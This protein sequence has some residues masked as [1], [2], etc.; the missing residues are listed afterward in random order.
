MKYLLVAILAALGGPASPSQSV[1]SGIPPKELQAE[2]SSVRLPVDNQQVT[3]SVTYDMVGKKIALEWRSQAHDGE[4]A[5]V[6]DEAVSFWPTAVAV[7]GE[8]KLLVAGKRDARGRDNTVIELWTLAPIAQGPLK[9]GPLGGPL[10]W[11]P[12]SVSITSKETVYDRHDV[13]RDI[14]KAMFVHAG[15]VDSVL[16][17]FHDSRD[18][19]TISTS[20]GA[21]SVELSA[22][23][24]PALA[25]DYTTFWSG[26]HSFHGYTYVLGR[27][28]ETNA[29]QPNLVL[30]DA[31]KDGS[32]DV[33]GRYSL[34][35]NGWI[36]MGFADD[37][38]WVD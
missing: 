28:W 11:Q 17:L 22:Q 31:D 9:V 29:G 2:W 16:A 4:V 35:V 5:A 8:N 21:Y 23:T 6:Q 1:S 7:F 38:N 10:T 34:D 19:Y 3:C 20:T 32:L 14:V 26:E 27:S 12:Y 36:T 25:D 30:T 37:A 18:L 13:G 33:N 24:E 15:T